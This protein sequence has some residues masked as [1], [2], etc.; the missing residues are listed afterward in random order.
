MWISPSTVVCRIHLGV[1][2]VR[3]TATM[4]LAVTRGEEKIAGP[5]R[6]PAGLSGGQDIQIDAAD[7]RRVRNP[8]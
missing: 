6:N 2:I 1:S 5:S 3:Q 4:K 7:D 8:E